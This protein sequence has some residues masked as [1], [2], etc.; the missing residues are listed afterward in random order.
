M[1]TVYNKGDKGKWWTVA[2]MMLAVKTG[3]ILQCRKWFSCK[4]TSGCWNCIPITNTTQIWVVVHLKGLSKVPCCRQKSPPTWLLSAGYSAWHFFMEWRFLNKISLDWPLTLT[5]QPSTSQ[6]SD[7]PGAS[8]VWNFHA[9]SSDVHSC[10]EASD[11]SQNIGCFLR[12]YSV[13]RCLFKGLRM[14]YVSQQV[15]RSVVQNL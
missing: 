7:N 4:M 9:C 1:F 12:L 11:L 8:S 6:L 10:K 2:I 15:K 5:T 14:A 3:N 13:W